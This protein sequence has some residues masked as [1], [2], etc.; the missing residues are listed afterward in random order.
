[1]ERISPAVEKEGQENI[2]K[3][4]GT[5]KEDHSDIWLVMSGHARIYLQRRPRGAILC[6]RVM[7]FIRT[8]F[9]W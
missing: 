2:A 3:I 6:E 1:V 4:Y 7:R 9:W 5:L 8:E